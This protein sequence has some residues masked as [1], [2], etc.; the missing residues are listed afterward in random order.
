MQ[1][2]DLH[3]PKFEEEKEQSKE[4]SSSVSASM[5]EENSEN[6]VNPSINESNAILNFN[7]DPIEVNLNYHFELGFP[8]LENNLFSLV[9]KHCVCFYKITSEGAN[10]DDRINLID[11]NGYKDYGSEIYGSNW[12]NDGPFCFVTDHYIN[13]YDVK[14]KKLLQKFL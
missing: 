1:K 2:I 7:D 8:S 3:E 12:L 6:I 9:S 4:M 13:I 11:E 5:K 14:E 10:E